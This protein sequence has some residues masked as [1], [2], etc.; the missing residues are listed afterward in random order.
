MIKKSGL[1]LVALFGTLALADAETPRAA[2]CN[3]NNNELV[4]QDCNN[5]E[6]TTCDC[7]P[8]EAPQ[9]SCCDNRSTNEVEQ[10]KVDVSVFMDEQEQK[11]AIVIKS[12]EQ[13]T[14]DMAQA[15]FSAKIIQKMDNNITV[16]LTSYRK[17]ENGNLVEH[18]SSAVDSMWGQ[19]VTFECPEAGVRL[20]LTATQA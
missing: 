14:V 5:C 11:G 9:K 18:S 10:I 12:H 20:M 16:N 3:E 4:A 13:V 15:L 19:A 2:S 7:T 6:C 1:F 17:M 8:C